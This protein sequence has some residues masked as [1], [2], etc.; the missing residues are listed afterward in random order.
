M[1][2]N[3]LTE[4]S[5]SQEEEECSCLY[6]R[7]ADTVGYLV[8]IAYVWRHEFDQGE[9]YYVTVEACNHA[10]L[11]RVTS[12]SSMT[13]DNSPPSPGHVTVGFEGHHSKFWGHK[14]VRQITVVE[15]FM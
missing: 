1:T 7:S 10:G 12:S 3:A 11:C 5:P 4:P 14:Y 2:C 8:S 15:V 13:F 6:S 9:K